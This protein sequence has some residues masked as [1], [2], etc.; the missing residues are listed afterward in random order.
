VTP[1]AF[2]FGSGSD[3]GAGLRD[4][5]ERVRD[6]EGALGVAAFEIADLVSEAGDDGEAFPGQ[7]FPDL[8]FENVG[9]F[10]T[11]PGGSEDEFFQSASWS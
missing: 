7:I 4:F 5:V 11:F 3:S 1:R 9:F 8:G 6:L 2:S 10:V